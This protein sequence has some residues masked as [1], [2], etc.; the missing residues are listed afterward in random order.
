M[1]HYQGLSQGEAADALG[2][3]QDALESLLARARRSLK[4]A[5][6]GEWNALLPDG[7]EQDGTVGRKA[8][9][10]HAE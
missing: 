5:L 8:G 9:Y 10:G 4:V 6:A 7:A 3:S 1:F 2:V